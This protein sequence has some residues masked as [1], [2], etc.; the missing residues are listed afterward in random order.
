M[1]SSSNAS[2][3]SGPEI[4][5]LDLFDLKA[6]EI[7]AARLL[8][9]ILLQGSQRLT[10]GAPL[11]DFLAQLL[12]QWQEVG[13]AIQEIDVLFRA[14]Q[15]H[16]FALPVYIDQPACHLLKYLL[17]DG[18]PIDTRHGTPGAE[19]VAREHKL[20]IFRR[21]VV[22]AQQG[23]KGDTRVRALHIR[24]DAIAP[25]RHP[26]LLSRRYG[27][28]ARASASA[29][30]NGD[31]SMWMGGKASNGE[32]AFYGGA[33]AAGAH[34]IRANL[35]AQQRAYGVDDNRLTRARLACKDV[36]QAMQLRCRLSIMAKSLIFNS[37]NI[38]STW[39]PA[40]DYESSPI[41]L[42]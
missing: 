2:T 21:N 36:K 40:R 13:V 19:N 26:S 20:P 11:G 18:A 38:C 33:F 25:T 14:Q 23:S 4:G 24:N 41:S 15:A 9:L 7:G 27:Y 34:E 30:S 35:A 29:A 16:M 31:Q 28:A 32:D 6:Q 37:S 39:K 3:S 12:A 10:G 22:F 42:A 8:F 1:R 5:L 17:R